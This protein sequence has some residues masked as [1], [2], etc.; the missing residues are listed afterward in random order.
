[1][2]ELGMKIEP[3]GLRSFFKRHN[4]PTIPNIQILPPPRTPQILSAG[5]KAPHPPHV[6]DY[7]PPMPDPHCYVRT[8]VRMIRRSQRFH[9]RNNEDDFNNFFNFVDAQTTTY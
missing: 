3:V 2:T 9:F 4:R 7:F 6:P 1:M 5:K 8:P